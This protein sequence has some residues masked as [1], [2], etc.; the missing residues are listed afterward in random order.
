MR[1]VW[2]DIPPEGGTL[3]CFYSDAVEHEVLATTRE[4][5]VI[6]GWIRGA[7]PEVGS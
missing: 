7:A 6:V 5:Q 3:V 4:R 1:P 2:D